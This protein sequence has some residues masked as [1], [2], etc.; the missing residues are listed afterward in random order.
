[1]IDGLDEACRAFEVPITGGNVSFYNETLGRG[2]Y[3]TPTLGVLGLLEDEAHALSMGFRAAG[4]LILLLDGSKFASTDSSTRQHEF[5]SSEY[6]RTIHGITSG[7]P[8]A[9]DLAGEKRLIK[10]LVALAAEGLLRS[11]HDLSDGGL[12]VALAESGFAS[13][14]SAD[15]L[16]ADV[17]LEGAE[18]AEWTLFNERGARAVVTA[19]PGALAAIERNA[20]KYELG[21]QALG[22]VTQG[23]FRIRYNGREVVASPVVSLHEGWAGSLERALAVR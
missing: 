20:A 6:A 11:A 1:V 14:F 13:F 5:S 2:I 21:L 16:G 23:T 18:P 10:A 3:P 9:I 19:A 12:A 7:A 22:T 15:W 8:P 17:A 4:D